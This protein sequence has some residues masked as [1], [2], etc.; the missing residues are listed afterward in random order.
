MIVGYV[1]PVPAFVA[2]VGWVLL[3]VGIV[4]LALGR[5]GTWG[6]RNGVF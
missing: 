4:L 5:S 1:A 3:I 2:T 6:P